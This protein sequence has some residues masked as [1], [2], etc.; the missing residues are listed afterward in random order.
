MRFLLLVI[1]NTQVVLHVC[2]CVLVFTC[3]YYAF[4]ACHVQCSL[5]GDL[6]LWIWVFIGIEQCFF[7]LNKM[8]S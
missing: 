3:M 8:K 2:E 5:C 7:N 4:I 1:L 6:T